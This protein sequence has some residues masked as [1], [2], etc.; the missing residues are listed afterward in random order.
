MYVCLCLAV[1]LLTGWRVRLIRWHAASVAEAGQRWPLSEWWLAETGGWQS[2][3]SRWLLNGGSSWLTAHWQVAEWGWQQ[4]GED[5]WE[6]ELLYENHTEEPG[7]KLRSWGLFMMDAWLVD[8]YDAGEVGPRPPHCTVLPE[9]Y[10]MKMHE[11]QD[12]YQ[13]WSGWRRIQNCV[14]L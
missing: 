4:Q 3:V 12:P 2:K 1:R 8:E 5:H 10:D 9:W 7:R 14:Y 13:I 6:A 11:E